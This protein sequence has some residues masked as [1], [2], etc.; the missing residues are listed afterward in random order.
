M[1][2]RVGFVIGQLSVGGAEGQLLE[3][4]RSLD[5]HFLPTVYCLAPTAGAIAGDLETLGIRVRVIGQRGAARALRL[6]RQLKKDEIDLV[7]SW[8]FIANGYAAAA[9]RGGKTLPLITS[10]RNCKV[11][12]RIS[13]L[14]NRYAFQSS[15][16]IVV[17][18]RDVE[19]YIVKHYEAPPDRIEVIHNGVDTERFHPNRGVPPEGPPLVVNIGRMVQQKNQDLFLDAAAELHRS[20]PEVR[21]M[22]VG[23]GPL[24][25]HLE[26]RAAGLGLSS[27]LSFPGERRDTDEILRR[28]SLFWLTSRWEGMPNVVLEAMASGVPVIATD[29][30]GTRELIDDGVEGHIVAPG[31]RTAIVERARA[32]LQDTS[33]REDAAGA[34]RR[35][36]ET[37]SPDEMARRFEDLYDRLLEPILEA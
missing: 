12:G 5:R 10:A 16:A 8:L 3:L 9:T 6:A 14:V 4:L 7:H 37:F 31:D 1:A 28:A 29:V 20:M 34:A 17:N 19:A 24:R 15:H 35:R 30:G 11:Q 21:F 36:A 33:R 27:V 2:M 26:Q 22:I 18:S 13:R 25:A 32:L 23:D